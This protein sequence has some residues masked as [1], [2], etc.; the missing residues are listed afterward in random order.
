MCHALWDSP[1]YTSLSNLLDRPSP[2]LTHGEGVLD[3]LF[4]DMENI[5]LDVSVRDILR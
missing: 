4:R 1:Q 3:A 2:I 5:T